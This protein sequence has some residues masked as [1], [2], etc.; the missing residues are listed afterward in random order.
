MIK[1]RHRLC[2][3][4]G[5]ASSACAALAAA[6][7]S[8]SILASCQT[9]HFY[10]NQFRDPTSTAPG[11]QTNDIFPTNAASLVD[12]SK[13]KVNYLSDKNFVGEKSTL[14]ITFEGLTDTEFDALQDHYSKFS[15][16][17][18]TVKKGESTY[19][20]TDFLPPSFQA[21]EGFTFKESYEMVS[22]PLKDL[23]YVNTVQ[24]SIN[25]W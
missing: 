4:H 21:L 9:R 25:C 14:N 18:S 12:K 5:G 2:F 17:K 11:L 20:L 19:K 8:G 23:P 3:V 15:R 24:T 10:V 1:A 6:M 16:V 13:I 7:L 22:V